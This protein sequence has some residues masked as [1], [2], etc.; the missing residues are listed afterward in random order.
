MGDIVKLP[1]QPTMQE[2]YQHLR[3]NAEA[4]VKSMETM[5]GALQREGKTTEATNL[6]V[7]ALMPWQAAIRD[8]DSGDLWWTCEACGEP[9]KDGTEVASEDCC[10][11][12][13]SCAEPLRRAE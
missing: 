8:D 3:D 11:L 2:R 1:A 5:V 12:H 13:G 9:I 10:W 7:W 4:F 6:R